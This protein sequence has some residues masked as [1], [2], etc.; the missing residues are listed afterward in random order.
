MG[1]ICHDRDVNP[2][3]L[4]SS[5]RDAQQLHHNS[6]PLLLLPAE[7]VD[8]REHLTGWIG[9]TIRSMISSPW[10]SSARHP[11]TRLCV[12]ISLTFVIHAQAVQNIDEQRQRLSVATRMT[13]RLCDGLDDL[14][15]VRRP[16][17]SP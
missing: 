16:D 3:D 2:K 14:G 12:Q 9:S 6:N 5:G 8:R 17:A 11:P 1:V 4:K 7:L 10:P 13:R 15:S